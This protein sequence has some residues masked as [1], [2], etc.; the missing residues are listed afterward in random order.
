MFNLDP[1]V[2]FLSILFSSIAIAYYSYGK[3]RSGHFQLCG[4]GLLVITFVVSSFWWL[5]IAGIVLTILPFILEKY[6]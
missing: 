1:G 6:S 2:L 3:K 5:L 4:A